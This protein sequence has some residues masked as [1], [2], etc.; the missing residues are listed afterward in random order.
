MLAFCFNPPPEIQ[1]YLN[2]DQLPLIVLAQDGDEI[3]GAAQLRF[4]EM[5]IDP[6]REHW[7]KAY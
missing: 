1:S 3:L 5:D 6:E 7:G 2:H 4:H